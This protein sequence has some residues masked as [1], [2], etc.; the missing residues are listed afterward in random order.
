MYVVM[1]VKFNPKDNSSFASVSL[2]RSVKVSLRLS[3]HG[4]VVPLPA[5]L[6]LHSPRPS[7]GSELPRVLPGHRQAVSGDRQRRPRRLPFPLFPRRSRSGTTRRAR[8]S[9]RSPATKTTS[10]VCS[11][12]RVSPTFSPPARTIAPVS[13]TAEPSAASACSCSRRSTVAGRSPCRRTATGSSSATTRASAS[14]RWVATSRPPAWT[15]RAAS[16]GR[17]VRR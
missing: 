8:A 13:S 4:G 6:Q 2:D 16:C 10:P 7:E 15:C 17:C 11:S 12:T 5:P 3:H 9:R 1:A 14:T